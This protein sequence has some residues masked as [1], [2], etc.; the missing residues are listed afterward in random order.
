MWL[1]AHLIAGGLL[2]IIWR[3]HLQSK[4][5]L[6]LGK[7]QLSHT[8]RRLSCSRPL[9]RLTCFRHLK[10]S[11]GTSTADRTLTLFAPCLSKYCKPVRGEPYLCLKVSG[12]IL[13]CLQQLTL[14]ALRLQQPCQGRDLPLRCPSLPAGVNTA[15]TLTVHVSVRRLDTSSFVQCSAHRRSCTTSMTCRMQ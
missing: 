8:D 1:S 6:A 13:W 10:T 5:A 11:S 14:R 12:L 2:A 15:V 3:D 9:G 4:A 7:L